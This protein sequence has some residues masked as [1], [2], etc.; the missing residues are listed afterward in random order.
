MIRDAQEGDSLQICQIYNYYIENSAAT[1]EEQRVEQCTMAKRIASIQTSLPWL[2][3]EEAGEILGYAYVSPWKERSAYRFAVESSI[4]IA[5]SAAGRGIGKRLYQALLERLADY[6]ISTVIAGITLPNPA[7][8]VLHERMGFNKVAEFERVG[9]KF[10][11]WMNVGYWQR[12]IKTEE[13]LN[14][15]SNRD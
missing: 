2:V 9:F 7:S 8:I 1:F 12:Q 3:Y 5:N 10:G 6:P 15:L 4:Y 14:H 11:N 13:Q